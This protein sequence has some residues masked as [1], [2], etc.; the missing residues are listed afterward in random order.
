MGEAKIQEEITMFHTL[1]QS[2]LLWYGVG[3]CAC[4][5]ACEGGHP[6]CHSLSWETKKLCTVHKIASIRHLII[7]VCQMATEQ[8]LFINCTQPPCLPWQQMAC[9][10]ATSLHASVWPVWPACAGRQDWVKQL[11]VQHRNL[12]S[13][14]P[15]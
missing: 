12:L 8:M 2:V 14:H 6:A 4:V 15:R 10:V 9:C 5:C 13:K 3:M 7:H 11:A 1:N